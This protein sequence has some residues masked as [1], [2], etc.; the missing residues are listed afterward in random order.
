MIVSNENESNAYLQILKSSTHQ[1]LVHVAFLV[2]RI[3]VGSDL[4]DE[5]NGSRENSR[6][7]SRANSS[8]VSRWLR[9]FLVRGKVFQRSSGKS[10]WGQESPVFFY[11]TTVL[12]VFFPSLKSSHCQAVL[13]SSSSLWK[14]QALS[15]FFQLQAVLPDSFCCLSGF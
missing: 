13:F 2:M 4:I 14:K 6:L 3:A 12:A 10:L 8:S 15:S 1:S 11:F 7:P 5:K 9:I